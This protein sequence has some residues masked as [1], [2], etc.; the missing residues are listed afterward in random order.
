MRTIELF[1]A[2]LGRVRIT[3]TLSEDTAAAPPQKWPARLDDSRMIARYM[4]SIS[5]DYVDVDMVEEYLQGAHADLKL[6]PI[7]ELSEGNQ[8][9]NIRDP[10]KE[11]KYS[12][13]DM[14]T[15]PPLVVQDGVILDGNHR[16]RIAKAK[17]VTALWCYVCDDSLTE[18]EIGG[19]I[20]K[21]DFPDN[22]DDDDLSSDQLDLFNPVPSGE[23]RIPADY[24][25]V[26]RMD[27]HFIIKKN[28]NEWYVVVCDGNAAAYVCLSAYKDSLNYPSAIRYEPQLQG[29]G[30]RSSAV[31]V[32]DD[33]RGK[34][35]AARLYRWVLENVC[36]YI[37]ADSMQTPDGVKLWNRLRLDKKNFVVSIWNPE[38]YDS[39]VP[40]RKRQMARVYQ[41]D[42]LIP[43]VTIP[44]KYEEVMDLG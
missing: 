11:A 13:L 43:W 31:Y 24:K 15:M 44:S 42:S 5:S 9:A 20:E 1:E 37:I 19:Y 33:Y 26:G 10:R 30:F 8:D 22:L 35:L 41:N 3:R 4:D 21:G 23:P 12:K 29:K 25:I 2:P 17:G 38:D 34:N 36:D 39:V 27:E 18:V 6:V 40:S 28:N 7:D 14:A 32:S 16:Y